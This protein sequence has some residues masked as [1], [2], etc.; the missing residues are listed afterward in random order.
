[1]SQCLSHDF[2]AA[3]QTRHA[4]CQALLEL[5][6]QQGAL[7]AAEDYDEFTTL[8][9]SKQALIDYLGQLNGETL[10][11]Q[12]TWPEKRDQLSSEERRRC[13]QLLADTEALLAELLEAEQFSSRQ[14]VERRDQTTRE[15]QSVAAGAQAQDAYALSSEPVLSRFDL[16]L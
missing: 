6:R 14:L 11:L 13:E 10:E 9:T 15:L 2:Q 3:F 1:M 4:C 12:R 5:S 7:I 8:L 16:N